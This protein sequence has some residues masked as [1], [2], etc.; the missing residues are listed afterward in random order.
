MKI[1]K[2]EKEKIKQYILNEANEQDMIE[3]IELMRAKKA[4]LDLE[5][6]QW[7]RRK[8]LIN[9]TNCKSLSPIASFFSIYECPLLRSNVLIIH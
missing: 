8:S 2:L 7:R 6:S 5:K 9:S 1:V 4:I 3:M